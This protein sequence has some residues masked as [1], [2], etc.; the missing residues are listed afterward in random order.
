MVADSEAALAM[1]PEVQKGMTNLVAES[2]K[3]FGTRHYRDYHFLFTLSDHVAHF[4]LEHHESNDSR[5]PERALLSPGAG[6]L[7][8]MLLPHE[9]VHSWNRKFRRPAGLATPDFEKPMQ[10]DLLWVYEGLTEYLGPLLGVRSGLFTPEQ[11]RDYLASAAAMLGP[12]R[13][14]RTWRPLLDTAV[15]VP[16]FNARGGGW[17][18]WRR[19]ADY[20]EE[21][22]LMW[23][24]AATIIHNVTHGQKSIDDFCHLFHGGA[25]N[26]PELKT[27]TFDDVVGALNQVAPD[28]W[29]AFF[30]RHLDSASP[31]TPSGGL[32]N[33]GW[34]V[35][36]TDKPANLPG[37]RG[38]PSDYGA[39]YSSGLIEDFA[40][41]PRARFA[42]PATRRR[43]PRPAQ[44]RAASAHRAAAP[45]SW[46]LTARTTCSPLASPRDATR[47]A[48]RCPAAPQNDLLERERRARRRI[49]LGHVV[50]LVDGEL[51][52]FE[53][54]QLRRQLKELL[55][56]D[57][58]I[59]AVQQAAA[60]LTASAF[61][62]FSF[63]YQPVVPTTMR[64]PSASTARMF[65][66]AASGAVK[67]TT[68]ST[69]A[70][71]GAVSAD[72]HARSRRCRARAR[73]G[74]A[75]AP[76]QPRGEPVFPCREQ[77]SA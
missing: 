11:Y 15:A 56:A 12:G 31:D 43:A 61:I 71:F 69:P 5:L 59:G 24:E 22:D 75:P 40:E 25:N 35:E 16:G 50:R 41:L 34:K 8:G 26:G 19:S 39:N 63:A 57:G 42:R 44:S 21:G 68:T 66:T 65:S 27:Y 76:P 6:A 2:G 7:V 3:L 67:S 32:E 58:K 55:H 72:A 23:L 38:A 53:L 45:V 51:V 18:S 73:R 9:F 30:H 4:G 33:A 54:R 47:S 20:Y 28:D 14:G 70:R 60:A 17:T 13:P 29:A 74:R 36:F 62:S 1:S 46:S 77:E 10:D 48:L 37:R 52:A 64:P 49:E